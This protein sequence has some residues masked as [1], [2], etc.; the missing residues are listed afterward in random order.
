MKR[1]MLVLCILVLML[2][3]HG[4]ALANA[5]EPPGLTVIVNNPPEG[6]TLSLQ[7]DN[8]DTAPLVAE[9]RFWEGQYKFYYHDIPGSRDWIKTA[10][11]TAEWSDRT[12]GIP[13]PREY[14]GYNNQVTLNL[15]TGELIQG[16]NP[17]RAPLL[18]AMRVILTLIIEGAILF[19]FG[20]RTR[21]SLIVFLILNL[22]TQTALNVVFIGADAYWFILY[23]IIEIGIFLLEGAVCKD[24]LTEHGKKRAIL[25][26][27]TA[28]AA[29]LLLGGWM[30]S[31]LPV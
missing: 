17:M 22:I 5:A 10:E 8:E 25:Y 15:K 12:L 16:Q 6:L 11:L 2:F 29:S 13:I 31:S 27:I 20:Y 9:H 28:N 3:L 1:K 24:R 19:A 7:L 23:V 26:S 4:L 30:I 18:T 21:Q 14:F